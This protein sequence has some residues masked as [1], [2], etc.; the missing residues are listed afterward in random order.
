MI[1][2]HH[3]NWEM[4]ASG[5]G[6]YMDHLPIGLYKRLS[7]DYLNKKMKSTRQR[8]RLVMVPTTETREAFERTFDEPNGIV[9]GID[10]RPSR[11][12]R[13]YWTTF[14]NQDTGV[15]FG[16]EKYAREYDRPV[17]YG[18]IHKVKRGHYETEFRLITEG[19]TS[20]PHGAILEKGTRMLEDDI[21]Q[22]PEFW[23]WSHKR[24]K[25]KKPADSTA[26]QSY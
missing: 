13:C 8:F 3:N 10:Q 11:A 22:A 18:V 21:R 20:E 19:P 14:L 17:I 4:F 9:F 16:A 5:V 1:G 15:A 6:F 24:W 2:G 25:V 26:S 7:N 23:L 12:N